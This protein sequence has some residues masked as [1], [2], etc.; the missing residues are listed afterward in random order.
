MNKKDNQNK[1]KTLNDKIGELTAGWQRTQADFLNYKKQASDERASLISSANAS[2]IYEIL[3]I[4]DNFKL[5]ADHMPEN[6]AEN[7]WAQGIK[8][9][10]RQLESILQ[11]EGLTRI[12]TVGEQFDPVLHEAI[13]HIE[14]G[15]PED[16]IVEEILPGYI[17]NSEVL[18]PAKVKVAKKASQQK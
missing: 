1:I 3:P 12:K 16:E 11:N 4:L 10:E 6:L 5:A 7:N 9:V 14:S 2:L 8:Q 18:R 17:L 13:E 15:K